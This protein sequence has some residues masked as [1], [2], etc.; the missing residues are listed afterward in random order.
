MTNA[1]I[2]EK[3]S[4]AFKVGS[5]TTAIFLGMILAIVTIEVSFSL[6]TKRS[7]T[8]G[9]SVN[10][11]LGRVSGA[12][13]SAVVA[14]V[15]LGALVAEEA[16]YYSNYRDNEGILLDG[17]SRYRLHFEREQLPATNAFWSLSLYD[18]DHFFVQNPINRYSL[19]DQSSLN[20]NED[21]SLDI[22]I[23]QQHDTNDPN[24]LPSANG[25]SG[26]TYVDASPLR[27][28]K[29][30]LRA[31]RN[32]P[33]FLFREGRLDVQHETVLCRLVDRNEVDTCF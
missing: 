16:L 15:G 2:D 29:R 3:P 18:H 21:G 14:K 33:S 17:Q 22:I 5:I 9:W 12:L 19:G 4:T 32:P 10:Y 13:R 25:P 7:P 11:D 31:F 1:E 30:L 23:A 20:Y 28:S 24:W 26:R 8:S 6:L 27:S